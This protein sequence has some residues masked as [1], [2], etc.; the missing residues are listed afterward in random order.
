MDGKRNKRLGAW[1]GVLGL[2]LATGA[3]AVQPPTGVERAAA[4]AISPT[5][6]TKVPH[7]F[8]PY[9][10]WA[11]SPQVLADAIVT[12]DLGTPTPV[13]V[14]NPLT[15]RSN[16]T[17]YATPPG[18]LG[19]VFVVLPS[20]VLPAGSLQSFQTFNQADP[21]GS[22]TPSAGGLFHAYVLR[23][24]GN[25]SQYTVVYDSGQLTV[26]ALAD[27]L[28]SEV[29][30][31]PVAPAVAVLAGDVVGFYGQGIP[32]DT[33]VTVN[34][35]IL[36]TPAPTAPVQG[37]T[38]ALGDPGFP[39]FS[40]DRT[41]SFSAMVTPTVP[42]P[43][44]GAQATATVD[45]KTGG[46][47]AITVTEPGAGYVVAPSVSITSPG[48]TPTALA[49]AT[50]VITTGAI[51]G[52]AVNETG[53]G[54]TTPSVTLTGGN[55]TT[56]ATAQAS[57][58]VDNVTLT[59]SGSGY[60]IQPIVE[61]GLPNLPGGIPATG[62]A[63]MDAA[64]VVTSIDVVNPGSGYT[65]APSVTIW[66]GTAKTLPAAFATA[67]SS[68]GIGQID[69]TS[70][71]QGYDTAPIVTITDS[72]APFDKNASAT[73]T[74]AVK[75]SVTA[76]NVT[77]PGAG[78][79]TPGLRKFVDT[80]SGL[81]PNAANNLGNY[82]P[83]AVPDTTTYPGADYYEIALVQYRQQFHSDLPQTLL[84]GYVQLSTDVVPGN[85]VQLTNANLDP[86]VAAAP[87]AGY[88]GVDTPHYL[89]PTI[90]ATKD[91]PVR[92][93]F[94]NLLPTGSG[95]DLFLPVDTSLMGSGAGPAMMTLDP[96]GVPVDMAADEGSVTDGVRNPM[97]GE[98]PK[99]TTCYSETGPPCTCTVASPRGSVTEL[100]TSGS[101]RQART[102]RTRR[103]S[104]SATC[105]TWPIPARAP[106]PSSTPTS[107]APG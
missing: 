24:T 49:S 48:V 52:I 45:P 68:I 12:I 2:C 70:G 80:L 82:I 78:Y 11:N 107:R 92:I 59:N 36:S 40:Q 75:G 60:V 27:P 9:P 35:D 58:G 74:V 89:G 23:P 96:N 83:V 94:R 86:S 42:A 61:F 105:P 57:G 28:V 99:P 55:P 67:T 53:F 51:T 47:S 72:V 19:P 77:A 3:V 50:A 1:L 95:G 18:V 84:R 4:A 25:P 20:S 44:T 21:A 100:L 102:P 91:R 97:C 71:G 81:G 34:P 64:G 76:I 46:I 5:D 38:L 6:E 17:D 56:P 69:I 79:L 39:N 65:S 29:A 16:A 87:I 22:P 88:F 85:H 32:V 103:V 13:A 90:V 10:N 106:R 8:G 26:P 63:T 31:F 41:Y 73:A 62:T 30:T 66:D 104:A 43:S 7:Y 93:L 15:G 98:T 101:P 54:F 37:I 14:G 33:G